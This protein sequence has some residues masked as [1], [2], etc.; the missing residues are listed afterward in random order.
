[1][2]YVFSKHSNFI[3]PEGALYPQEIQVG[4]TVLFVDSTPLPGVMERWRKKKRRPSRVFRMTLLSREMVEGV[5][6]NRFN[7]ESVHECL[8]AK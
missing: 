4:Q 8:D 5:E 3:G 7:I 2:S 6:E 1:M